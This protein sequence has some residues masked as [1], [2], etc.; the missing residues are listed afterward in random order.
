[1]SENLKNVS[2]DLHSSITMNI[3]DHIFF[4]DHHHF[5]LYTFS[6][7]SVK[8]FRD[9]NCEGL[10]VVDNK[11]CYTLSHTSGHKSSG[12]R[13]YDINNILTKDTDVS[14]MLSNVQVGFSGLIDWNQDYSRFSLLKSLDCLV[15]VPALHRNTIAFI[16]MS[17]R[18]TYLAT[19]VI[20]D[21][22]IA[23][24]NKNYIFCWSVVSGKL[25]SVHKLPTR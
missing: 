21:K 10:Y 1:M 25:L 19:K 13:L 8:I 17:K 11:F 6:N 7:K 9:Q 24:D 4:V 15:I 3:A 20:K 18:E 22:F 5:Y 14:Y 12:L 23:L 16:G 2:G